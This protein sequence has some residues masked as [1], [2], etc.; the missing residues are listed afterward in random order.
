MRP[1]LHTFF[2]CQFLGLNSMTS[3]SGTGEIR[4]RLELEMS[5]S[6]NEDC[7]STRSGQPE[8]EPRALPSRASTVGFEAQLPNC[9]LTYLAGQPT[10]P[11]HLPRMCWEGE[12]EGKKPWARR[13]ATAYAFFRLCDA[14]RRERRVGHYKYET[15]FYTQLAKVANDM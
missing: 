3:R 5:G 15:H 9:Q 6:L 11:Q 8:L 2:N 14:Y 7:E 13:P 12:S 4:L 10:N 1:S